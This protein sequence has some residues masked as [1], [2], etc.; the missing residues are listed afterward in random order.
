MSGRRKPTLFATSLVAVLAGLS[1]CGSRAIEPA[2]PTVI[3]SPTATPFSPNAD[4]DAGAQELDRYW[5]QHR[6]IMIGEMHG[7][8]ETPALV[9]RLIALRVHEEPVLAGLEISADEQSTVDAFLH[10]DGSSSARAKL[11]AGAHWNRPMQDGRS[12][13]AIVQLLEATRVLRHAG[14]RIDLVCFDLGGADATDAHADRDAIMAA[15]LRRAMD[16][17]PNLRTISLS[18]NVHNQIREKTEFGTHSPMAWHLR[19]L[20]PLSI[21]IAGR[22][23]AMW[24]CAPDCGVHDFDF[25]SGGK[26]LGLRIQ[27]MPDANGY[28]GSLRLAEFTASLPAISP[29][30]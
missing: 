18:G 20:G 8:N 27:E 2:K 1:G 30:R 10:S 6:L 28:H 23:G 3:A 12:G 14:R 29:K 11:L 22:H 9:A 13:Q 19:D 16:A 5:T 21:N 26:P 7:T 25:R 24:N 4:I 15:N 17:H